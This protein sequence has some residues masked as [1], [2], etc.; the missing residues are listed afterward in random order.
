MIK[1]GSYSIL[2]IWLYNIS[3]VKSE[4]NP[5]ED[6]LLDKLLDCIEMDKITLIDQIIKGVE[7]WTGMEQQSIKSQMTWFVV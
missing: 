6:P 2:S 7:E 4:D 3:I 5:T 1:E